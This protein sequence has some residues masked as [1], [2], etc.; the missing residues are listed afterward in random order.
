MR[1][2]TEGETPHRAAALG[3]DARRPG[4]AASSPRRAAWTRCRSR[5][6]R[7]QASDRA[8][9]STAIRQDFRPFFRLSYTCPGQP[10]SFEFG[11]RVDEKQPSMANGNFSV[12][13]APHLSAKA[14]ALTLL[15]AA[16][17]LFGA[18]RATAAN[19]LQVAPSGTD[20]GNCVGAACKTIQYGDQV[21]TGHSDRSAAG[22]YPEPVTIITVPGLTIAGNPA[23]GTTVGPEGTGV[24][25]QTELHPRRRRR[26]GHPARPRGR[27]P[28]PEQTGDPRRRPRSDRRP[29]P[30]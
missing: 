24:V 2:E 19:T 22:N 5:R 28:R 27:L 18:D 14:L 25:S 4:L 21:A 6:S 15:S 17:L 13:T 29:H 11:M 3:G 12:E 1:V 16:L 23:G 8:I 30:R 20:T 10:R 26:R 9:P 7:L